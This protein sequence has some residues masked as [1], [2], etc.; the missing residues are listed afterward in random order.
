[1]NRRS[2]KLSG[3]LAFASFAWH[4]AVLAISAPEK[5]ALIKM[6]REAYSGVAFL[7][8]EKIQKGEVEP[9]VAETTESSLIL[10]W[11]IDQTA[12]LE[13]FVPHGF[14][15]AKNSILEN[16]KEMVSLNLEIS[17]Q[18][19]IDSGYRAIWFTFIKK[20]PDPEPRVL[21][22]DILSSRSLV[23]PF[24][25]VIPENKSLR[26]KYESDKFM[27]RFRSDRGDLNIQGGFMSLD[28]THKFSESWV[29]SNDNIYRPNAI[30]DRIFYNG[31][32]IDAN[33]R[34]ISK[35]AFKVQLDGF[36]KGIVERKVPDVFAVEQSI[37]RSILPWNNLNNADLPIT[38]EERSRLL[39]VKAEKY[40]NLY[41]RN[42]ALIS[43]GLEESMAGFRVEE[44][45]PA[46]FVN[47]RILDEKV[48]SFEDA[49]LPPG[50]RLA[51]VA[52]IRGK[53]PEFMMSLNV[54]G[55]SGLAPGLRAEWSVYVTP[56]GEAGHPYFMVIDVASSSR[57]LDPVSLWT[58]P[59]EEFLYD[60]SPDGVVNNNISNGLKNFSLSFQIPMSREV[61]HHKLRGQWV[62]ANDR[63]YWTNG[64]YDR[65]Y[66]NGEVLD[67]FVAL[68]DLSRVVIND[69]TPW[70]NYI[71]NR[72][73]E[74][75][76]FREKQ[77]YQIKAWYNVEEM[78]VY[79]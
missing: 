51:K 40:A 39:G 26:Y 67:T 78:A 4:S 12:Q 45:P 11:Q 32:L 25:G 31:S 53:K 69:H 77:D 9:V 49:V 62:Q 10:S 19:G 68:A 47:W 14:Q 33:V 65:V 58:E 8:A 5:E 74:L 76:V 60:V 34:A 37:E 38:E 66:Y 61:Y 6:K 63:V 20:S 29:R 55:A 44:S 21:L 79:K 3:I 70:R 42:G 50:F 22:L 18:S 30:M 54:Y 35:R 36:W 2:L 23:D 73:L 13:K 43:Q 71:D 56:E 75:V 28:K 17:K 1:M 41:R 46:F 24:F 7:S 64:V 48:S 27:A 15:I 57:S 52:M 59:A 72:P 16:G